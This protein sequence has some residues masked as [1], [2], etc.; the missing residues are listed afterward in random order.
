MSHSRRFLSLR[1][2]SGRLRF[3][4][5]TDS[6]ATATT[7]VASSFRRPDVEPAD[8]VITVSNAVL[9]TSP[10]DGPSQPHS[11]GTVRRLLDRGHSRD[12][13]QNSYRHHLSARLSYLV[14]GS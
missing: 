3:T 6:P 10:S 5:V 12:C 8:A 4:I 1:A 13:P 7:R 2:C 9:Y 14:C 11:Q